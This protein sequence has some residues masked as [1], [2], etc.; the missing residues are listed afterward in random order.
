MLVT[1]GKHMDALPCIYLFISGPSKKKG[2]NVSI[3]IN[4]HIYICIKI[5][6]KFL[7][8]IVKNQI[9]F[10]YIQQIFENYVL[11]MIDVLP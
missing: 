8:E 4:A 6:L 5:F 1:F 3:R 7:R 2:K 10:L 9:S 11:S